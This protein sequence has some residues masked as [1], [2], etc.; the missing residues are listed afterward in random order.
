MLRG[1]VAGLG[2]VVV[3]GAC[4]DASTT[5][6][7]PPTTPA[8]SPSIASTVDPSTSTSEAATPTTAASTTTTRTVVTTTT[9]ATTATATTTMPEPIAGLVLSADG[10]GLVSFEEP[11]DDVLA[12]LIDRLGPPTSD[13]IHESTWGEEAP[14]GYFRAVWWWDSSVRLYVE[15]VDWSLDWDPLDTPVFNFWGAEPGEIPLRTVEGVGPGTPWHEAEAIYGNRAETGQDSEECGGRWY[16]VVDRGTGNS[17]HAT[18][19]GGLDG[20]PSDPATSITRMDT[21]R[22]A[23]PQGC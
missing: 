7:S 22:K 20:D 23:F 2:V 13:E 6:S 16:Y 5:V 12:I 1:F 3:L 14:F 4:T 11:M 8:E 18:F 17:F 15:F 19:R 21:G 10:L 9:V